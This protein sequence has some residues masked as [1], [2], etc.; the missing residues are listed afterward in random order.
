[1]SG[2]FDSGL[3]SIWGG[4]WAKETHIMSE[5]MPRRR[6]TLADLTLHPQHPAHPQHQQQPRRL[7]VHSKNNGTTLDLVAPALTCSLTIDPAALVDI[8]VSYGI[9]RIAVKV[10]AGSNTVTASVP[11]KSLR[12]AIDT[13]RY[14]G[15]G[16]VVA[17]LTVE[18][19]GAELHQA[20]VIAEMPALRQPQ[21]R[22]ERV[23]AQRRRPTDDSG[24]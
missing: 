9:P 8:S 5:T 24:D 1:M 15:P 10:Q 20:V 23:G 16:N 22:H 7:L 18:L 2:E 14:A 4:A 6:L 11:A 12:R 3:S 17:T 19:V 21:P 13:I